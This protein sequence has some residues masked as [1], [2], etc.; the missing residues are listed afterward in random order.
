MD[1]YKDFIIEM[2]ENTLTTLKHNYDDNDAFVESTDKLIDFLELEVA[3][4]F[5]KMEEKYATECE[6]Y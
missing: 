1:S 2:T 5:R 4:L 6:P 3:G